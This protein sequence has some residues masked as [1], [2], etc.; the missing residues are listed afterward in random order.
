[1]RMIRLTPSIDTC[2][3]GMLISGLS[4]GLWLVGVSLLMGEEL[5]STVEL[6]VGEKKTVGRLMALN[7]Q[8]AM[9]LRRD[10][11]IVEFSRSEIDDIKQVAGF[12]PYSAS[13]L[14]DH[15]RKMFGEG[16]EVTRTRYYVIIHPPGMRADWADPFDQLYH[17]FQYYFNVRGFTIRPAEFPLIVM[18]FKTRGE[19]NRVARKDG[20]ESP[21][22]YAGYYSS[23]SN[24]IVTYRDTHG[25]GPWEKNATLIHEA[26]HQFAFNHGIH[27]RWAWTPQWCAEGLATMFE[28]RGIN[29]SRQFRL[30]KD[31]LNQVYLRRLKEAVQ[32]NQVNGKL[33]Y[34]IASD[35]FFEED[36]A[37]AYSMAWGLAF[38][39]AET[40]P[41]EFNRYLQRISQR[42]RMSPYPSSDRLADFATSFGA[43]FSMLD[44]RFVQFVK[45]LD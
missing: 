2:K 3:R 40:Q 17:R 42:D 23:E 26:L 43:D 33:K 30:D 13:A 10:G 39:L 37:L 32:T 14:Q 20:I 11:R 35:R 7:P 15:Y 38:Y 29:N 45:K 8:Q 19:F 28:A 36:M 16:Y 12:K 24:W 9:V 21:N 44:S 4:L 22:A 25:G 27:Q 1:M 41:T 5:K 18:V 34:L 31:R 6:R